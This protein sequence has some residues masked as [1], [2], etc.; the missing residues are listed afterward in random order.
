VKYWV[1]FILG[2][3]SLF[4]GCRILDNN[5][6]SASN[7]DF[8]KIQ[9]YEKN[10]ASRIEILLD[11]A[12]TELLENY[13]KKE[14]LMI[15]KDQPRAVVHPRK[16]LTLRNLIESAYED[17][18]L[19]NKEFDRYTKRCDDLHSLWEKQWHAADKKARILGYDR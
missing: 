1:S 17:G 19:S 9:E 14:F 10:Y 5:S 6:Y 2:S 3:F 7:K 12:E 15:R 18:D 13:K 11:L 16:D 4:S 8:Q